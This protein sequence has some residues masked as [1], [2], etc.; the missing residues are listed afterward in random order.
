MHTVDMMKKISPE[1]TAKFWRIT[2]WLAVFTIL[3]NIAEGLVSIYF[4]AED[5]TLTL[6]GFGVD[7]F[8][9]VL[10][11]IGIFAMVLRIRQNPET[12]RS[13]F[14]R[15]ALR[16][17]GTAFYILA[18]GL[19]ISGIYNLFTVH[20][21][22]TTLPGLIIAL[23]SI[24]IMW[25]L[26]AAKRKVGHALAS[27]PILADANCTMVCIYMS[28]VLLA[29]S[30]INELTG[31]G[32]ADSLGAFGLLYFSINEGREAFEKAKAKSIGEEGDDS[33]SL[34]VGGRPAIM[35]FGG[36]RKLVE[37]ED[38]DQIPCDGTEVSYSRLEVGTEEEFNK[39]IKGDSVDIEYV[40]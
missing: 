23:V 28:L 15:A 36:I 34:R 13:Q 32:L 8:I 35:T 9:E 18:A 25:M 16:L 27:A 37:C 30:L 5:E 33:E 10:S 29:S 11:G 24:A 38:S 6:F 22:K 19:G 39:L 17:T 14:E 1:T 26:V 21:P 3:Y 40:E 20:E 4:G 2:L 31:F 12:P 7:S